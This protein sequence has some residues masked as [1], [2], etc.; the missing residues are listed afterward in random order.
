MLSVMIGLLEASAVLGDEHGV[1]TC[2]ASQMWRTLFAVMARLARRC[3][4]MQAATQQE[5]ETS[6]R[7][8]R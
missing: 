5:Q 1:V 2:P 3:G 4:D 7:R 6:E 8:C